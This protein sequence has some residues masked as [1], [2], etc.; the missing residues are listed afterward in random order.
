MGRLEVDPLA[1]RHP[2]PDRPVPAPLPLGLPCW[3]AL[4]GPPRHDHAARR[5]H[6]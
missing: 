5:P 4:A 3:L 6:M 2:A 1:S